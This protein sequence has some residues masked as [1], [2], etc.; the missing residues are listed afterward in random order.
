M[1]GPSPCGHRFPYWFLPELVAAVLT[2]PKVGPWFLSGDLLYDMKYLTELQWNLLFDT[3]NRL[4][5]GL[6]TATKIRADPLEESV[7]EVC[8]RPSSCVSM[9]AAVDCEPARMGGVRRLGYSPR[10]PLA[11][12]AKPLR[13]VQ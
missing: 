6:V 12:L 7:M 3:D 10:L 1:H 8:P 13:E 5:E 11:S 2:P 9:R 4:A